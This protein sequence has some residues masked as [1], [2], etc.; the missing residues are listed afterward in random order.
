M[1][2]ADESLLRPDPAAVH[3]LWRAQARLQAA[4]W[5]HVEVARRMAERLP[6]LRKAP[7][8]WIDWFAHAGG[9]AEA[10]QRCLPQARRLVVEADLA[11]AQRSRDSAKGPWWRRLGRQ[12]DPVHVG[13][14]PD[15]PGADL[16][17]ANMSLL[18]SSDAAGLMAHWHA[19]LR[20]EG[21]VMLTTLG[22][23]SLRELRALHRAQG[24]SPPHLPFM[25]MHDLGDLMV[26]SG[27]ADPVI[28]QEHLTL[29]WPE[30]R[31]VLDELRTLGRN[32]HPRR[33]SGLRTPRWRQ[34]WLDAMAE[35][36][37]QGRIN[38]TF[39]VVYAQAFKVPRRLPATEVR[40]DVDVLRQ[41]LR[42][43]RIEGG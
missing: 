11:L 25:D 5:L 40:I 29:N 28:D 19:A 18:A 38:L 12:T 30:P 4:P 16:L 31:L 39:E 21:V 35:Q 3:R 22:P 10:V 42:I 15:G 33:H 13:H 43:G 17:W 14:V 24:W 37:H 8:L 27:F 36:A 20:D 1:A 32:L 7:G 26:A 9:S 41:R 6:L 34:Q 23:D 2:E